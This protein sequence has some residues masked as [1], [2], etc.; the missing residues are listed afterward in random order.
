MTEAEWNSC[1]EPEKMLTFLRGSGRASDRKLRLF[2]VAV[3]RRIWPLLTDER[4]RR[5]IVTLERHV[6]GTA[7]DQ[8][9]R[10][11]D[12]AAEDAAWD[13][14]GW[15]GHRVAVSVCAAAWAAAAANWEGRQHDCAHKAAQAVACGFAEADYDPVAEREERIT[16]AILLRD[17]FG[18]LRFREVAANPAWLAPI[19]VTLAQ[20]AYEHRTLPAG[21][22]DSGRLA[23]LRSPGPH[24]RGCFALDLLLGRE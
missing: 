14:D 12:S 2:A 11:A 13:L 10:E 16:Q 19:V 22:L 3:C 5:V 24:V 8:E 17:I 21:H 7:S 6:E 20:A 4:S 9:L 1:R 15:G 18:P 23:H